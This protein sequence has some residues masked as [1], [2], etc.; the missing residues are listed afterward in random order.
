MVGVILEGTARTAQGQVVNIS[1]EPFSAPAT[2]VSGTEQD[3]VTTQQ[4]VCDILFL[5]IGP[6]HLNLLGLVID[7][8]EI[9]INIDAIQGGGLLGDLLCA[10]ANLLDSGSPIA[11]ILAQINQLLNT[12]LAILNL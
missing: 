9:V 8:S 12:I 3:G 4:A 5:D 7:I 10:L 11:N 1:N 6:I 2:L